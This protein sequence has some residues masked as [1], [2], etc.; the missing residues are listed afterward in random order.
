M[1]TASDG[2]EKPKRPFLELEIDERLD[3]A[4]L[5]LDDGVDDDNQQEGLCR[6][7]KP[8][9]TTL[10]GFLPTVG[11]EMEHVAHGHEDEH[12]FVAAHQLAEELGLEVGHYLVNHRP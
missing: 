3:V 8:D 9:D 6:Q 12:H 10:A 7:G 4:R 5:H 2:G 1:R 11:Q